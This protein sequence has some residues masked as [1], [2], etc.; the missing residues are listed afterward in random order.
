M[1]QGFGLNTNIFETNILNLAVVLGIVVTVVGD[2]LR[3]ILNQ[4]R[5]NILSTLAEADAKSRES[6]NRLEEAKKSVVAARFR[7]Q[8]I[9]LQAIQV[10]EQENLSA[11]SKLADDLQRLR[12]RGRQ[13][14]QLAR[15]Q[16]VQTIAQQVASLAVTTAESTL[17]KSF[18][19]QTSATSKQ[20]ELNE[21]HVSETLRTLKGSYF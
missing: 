7:A 10:A 6:Q 18:G 12:D 13:R 11:Q 14:I 1:R 3:S 20:I 15:Q 16:T 17:L 21:V 9:R 2:A 4:R 8:E 19:S 5:Q